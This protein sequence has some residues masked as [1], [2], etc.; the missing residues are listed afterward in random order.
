MFHVGR[1]TKETV[2]QIIR[3][4]VASEGAFGLF[5]RGMK[6]IYQHCAEKHLH[7]WGGRILPALGVMSFGIYVYHLPI[8]GLIDWIDPSWTVV[9]LRRSRQQRRRHI[10]NDLGAMP[11]RD[12]AGAARDGHDRLW[13]QR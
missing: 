9:R 13:R 5:K 10:A 11:Q 6:G 3:E 8:R 12:L 7:R 4:N 1:A 2:G